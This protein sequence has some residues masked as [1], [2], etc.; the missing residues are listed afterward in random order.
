MVRASAAAV[1]AFTAVSAIAVIKLFYCRAR[2]R[3]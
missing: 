3:D 2:L 1:L